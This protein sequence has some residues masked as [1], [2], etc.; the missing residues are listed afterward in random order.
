[1]QALSQGRDVL[2][3]TKISSVTAEIKGRISAYA[4]AIRFRREG[5]HYL[6][7]CASTGALLEVANFDAGVHT[8]LRHR[9]DS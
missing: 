1:M 5:S 4:P 2:V 7:S 3:L 8:N 9:R 6:Y